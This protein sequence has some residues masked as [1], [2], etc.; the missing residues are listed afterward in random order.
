MASQA[1]NR[2]GKTVHEIFWAQEVRRQQA[3]EVC[4]E[5]EH[6][7]LDGASEWTYGELEQRRRAV[8]DLASHYKEV[9]PVNTAHPWWGFTPRLL[10]PGDEYHLKML[11]AT[12]LPI[13]D[14]LVAAAEE[15]ELSAQLEGVPTADWL[16]RARDSLAR[17]PEPPVNLHQPF[18][19]L[20][21]L[22]HRLPPAGL[23]QRVDSFISGIKSA[24]SIGSACR[25]IIPDP[26]S[27]DSP[28]LAQ[29][30]E[31]CSQLLADEH[32]DVALH[33][34]SDRAEAVLRAAKRL[35]TCPL[36]TGVYPAIG[37]PALLELERLSQAMPKTALGLTAR[38]LQI[39]G[40]RLQSDVRARRDAFLRVNQL[41]DRWNLPFDGTRESLSRIFSG[42][43]NPVQ[44]P[45]ADITD[46]LIARASREAGG[47]FSDISLTRIIEAADGVAAHRVRLNDAITIIRPIAERV[48]LDFNQA[49]LRTVEALHAV[50]IACNDTPHDLLAFRT[51]GYLAPDFD[52][53]VSRAEIAAQ[54]QA[55]S[56]F[57]LGQYFYLDDLPSAS[58]LRSAL[59]TLRREKG[60][61]RFFSGEWRKANKLIKTITREAAPR[62]PRDAHDLVVDLITWLESRSAFEEDK[63]LKA[64][65]GALFDGLQTD[66]L[67]ARTL[68]QWVQRMTSALRE[69]PEYFNLLHPTRLSEQA[70]AQ[71]GSRH[72][73]VESAA[74]TLRPAKVRTDSLL[75]QHLTDVADA[76]EQGVQVL[77]DW[78]ALFETGLR[79]KHQFFSV[80]VPPQLSPLEALSDL[81]AR[82]AIFLDR[83]PIALLMSP[84]APP[85]E[86][87]ALWLGE[88]VSSDTQ[89][90]QELT[91]AEQLAQ[92]AIRLGESIEKHCGIDSTVSASLSALRWEVGFADAT[93][94]LLHPEQLRVIDSWEKLTAVSLEAAGAAKGIF[95]H[96][97]AACQDSLSISRV[98]QALQRNREASA[99]LRN[100]EAS[101][102]VRDVLGDHYQG[103]NT[104]IDVLAATFQWGR[105]AMEVLQTGP[106]KLSAAVL[107]SDGATN[108]LTLRKLCAQAVS[109]HDAVRQHLSR[110][111]EFGAINWDYWLFPTSPRI[112]TRIGPHFP[113]RLRQAHDAAGTVLAWSRY[114]SSRADC[115]ELGLGVLAKLLEQQKLPVDFL[116]NAFDFIAHRSIARHIY[117]QHPELARFSGLS[118]EALRKEYQVLDAQLIRETGQELAAE[119][120]RR[121]A[122][123]P[124]TVGA[125][126]GDFTELRL[127]QR[128]VEKQKKHIPIRQLVKR[129]GRALQEL[130]P[131]FMMGPLSVAQYLEPGAVSFDLIVMDEASQ[132]R[133]ED[134]LGA[135]ARGSQLVVVGDP[136]QLPPTSFFD[137]LVDSGDDEDADEQPNIAVGVE[138]ILDIC[139]QLFR[140]VRTLRWHYRS[141]HESLIAFSNHAFYEGSLVI[142][143]S[144]YERGAGL[145]VY[146][147]YIPSGV[148]QDRKNIPEAQSLVDAVTNHMLQRTSRV[149][150]SNN[151]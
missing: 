61:F 141:Q 55:D 122:P 43:S 78:L 147:R 38:A 11:L 105:A 95:D 132:L 125:R 14:E 93:R 100:L 27:L 47:A 80:L 49:K 94:R 57:E 86:A 149:A 107:S 12:T 37:E 8:V 144:P 119:I 118:H 88:A 59:R 115:H 6:A 82:R 70:I 25:E 58:E 104:D 87:R 62:N 91:Q 135:I 74:A 31:A 21:F 75:G 131:C 7:V 81:R 40:E 79:K 123:P 113:A 36:E 143:P 45:D 19:P 73:D 4:S 148:Y 65:L 66:F 32:V 96:L 145:G 142:F 85:H 103:V 109:L 1:G 26:D 111:Q 101:P 106:A 34:L 72:A 51:E 50:A 99:V 20:L 10:A 71:I 134:A 35:Q 9:Q 39:A 139:R 146:S 13:A 124:G 52:D 90:S 63:Q 18:L 3:G 97:R 83:E 138:S 24:K 48:G 128:E 29:H 102:L 151:S 54:K 23:A 129:A 137:R 68:R 150:R 126:A 56:R 110:L 28:V 67:K 16:L 112:S 17:I 69:Y 114:C 46:E 92:A 33:E 127:I 136:K 140:P 2:L 42:T 130:K 133:P 5:V 15:I 116:E 117:Q 98:R 108:F 84:Y 44:L 77:S 121:K 64:T 60:A 30:L 41:V 53:L 89:L 120:D 76:A 22:Q